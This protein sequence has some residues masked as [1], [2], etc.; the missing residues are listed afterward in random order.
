M[1]IWLRPDKLAQYNLTPSDVATAI[2][3]Q[4]SQFAAG[5]FGD[6]PDNNAQPFTYTVTTQG[7]L[8][9]VD[10]FGDIILRSDANAATLRL[11][12]VARIEL[13]TK[14][15]SIQSSLNGTPAIPYRRLSA[16]GRQRVEYDVGSARASRRTAEVLPAGHFLPDPVR[17][18]QVHPGVDRGGDP[19]L[20]R[21]DPA[22][23]H[24]RLRLPCRTGGRRSFP[25]S[26]C[27]SRSSAPLPACMRW[28]SRSTC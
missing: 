18:D 1:R 14:S 10:A 5:T 25:S 7:R 17:H 12:D 3:E 8:P 22:R 21:S 15:Y 6:Q 9:D 28:D 13:G 20:H 27:R 19:H 16:A 26:P 2:Q 4:N 11:K 24:R 23:R